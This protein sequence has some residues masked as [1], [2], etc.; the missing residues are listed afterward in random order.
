[1][2]LIGGWQAR[3][4]RISAVHVTR[5]LADWRREER[6]PSIRKQRQ[7][8]P[9]PSA[10]V[11]ATAA[12]TAAAAAA[13]SSTTYDIKQ[14]KTVCQSIE[15]EQKKWK[16]KMMMMKRKA[17]IER[18]VFVHTEDREHGCRA[19][20][21]EMTAITAVV[22]VRWLARVECAE[23]CE[24]RS[25]EKRKGLLGS[26]LLATSHTVV[27]AAAAADNGPPFVSFVG[28]AACATAPKT[29]SRWEWETMEQLCHWPLSAL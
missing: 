14:T 27:V 18:I 2:W 12:A 24:Q 7:W 22:A 26:N 19:V 23:D 21:M 16:W 10:A 9:S 29:E 6:V 11:A 8:S 28:T 17:V 1:M 20:W 13:T 4:C 3:K 25:K 5:L 15:V